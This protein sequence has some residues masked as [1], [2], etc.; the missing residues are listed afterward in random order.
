MEGKYKYIDALLRYYSTKDAVYHGKC[1]GSGCVTCMYH[2]DEWDY[3]EELVGTDLP[4]ICM[5]HKRP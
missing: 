2:R 4:A 1:N 5:L 3:A